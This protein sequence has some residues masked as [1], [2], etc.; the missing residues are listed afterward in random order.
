MNNSPKKIVLFVVDC[1]SDELPL[2]LILS[3]LIT[4][5]HVKFHVVH[6]DITSD[7][8]NNPSNNM[9]IR[10]KRLVHAF[11]GNIY[12]YQDIREIIHIVDID[13]VYIDDRYVLQADVERLS[14]GDR[15]IRTKNTRETKKR[16]LFKSRALN[17][18]MSTKKIK[19]GRTDTSEVPYGLYYMSCNLD[20][21]IHN[22]RNLARELKR[23]KATEFADAYYEKEN[24]FFDF[25]NRNDILKATL[26]SESWSYLEK[27][28]NS[29][30]RC[31][32]LALYL[33]RFV[34]EDVSE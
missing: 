22:E 33:N 11:L 32:N 15:A 2:G 8:H 13:G 34:V 20:H 30:S 9:I 6:G 14:Y 21:V 7:Y 31:S 16:N 26:Y 19:L 3:K 4:S 1:V 12:N 10:V 18:L 27:E 23:Q 17:S 5:D 28:F 24:L 25:L 29:L